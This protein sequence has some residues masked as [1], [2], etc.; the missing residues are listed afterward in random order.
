MKTKLAF[1]TIIMLLLITNG[2]CDIILDNTHHVDKCVKITNI[3]DYPDVCLVVYVNEVMSYPTY[4]VSS[5]NC[6]TKGYKYN[7]LNV[8]AVN[9]SY[10][11][12]KDISR[13][14]WLK[15]AHALPSNIKIE[16]EGG[17]VHDSIPISGIEEYYRIV[18][19]SDSNVIIYKW[20]QVTKFNNG[21]PDLI[22]NIEYAEPTIPLYQKIMV[23]THPSQNPSAIELYPNPATKKIHLRITDNYTGPLSVELVTSTG[24]AM[25]T[26]SLHKLSSVFDYDIPVANVAKGAYLVKVQLGKVIEY[27][28]IILK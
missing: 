17:Y 24:K 18:G 13:I 27:E 23:G 15:D 26:I 6:L 14:N 21:K 1:F 10:L 19:F 4:I 5:A 9:K 22:E 16:P 3:E 11:S 12:G 8:L 25:K 2:Y 20:K 28:K 7:V